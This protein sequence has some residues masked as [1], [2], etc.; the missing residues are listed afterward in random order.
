M[1]LESE[2]ANGNLELKAW[3][4]RMIRPYLKGRSLEIA[5]GTGFMHDNFIQEDIPIHISDADPVV[6]AGLRQIFK[7]KFKAVHGIHQLDVT[8]RD[9][10]HKHPALKHAFDTVLSLNLKKEYYLNQQ[11]LENT[12]YL[13]RT[14]GHLIFLTPVTLALFSGYD[15]DWDD[16]KSKCRPFVNKL[17]SN[18]FTLLKARYFDPNKS[19]NTMSSNPVY[20]V[21]LIIA[22]K[23]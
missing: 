15:P 12:K 4:F 1:S 5:S 22:R 6:C 10:E 13:L 17:V 23:N 11:G 21:A 18:Y 16:F 9:L 3:M 14:R 20:P 2:T 7:G 8:G 19:A